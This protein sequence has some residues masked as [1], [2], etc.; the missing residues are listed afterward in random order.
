MISLK[1]IRNY[2]DYLEAQGQLESIFHSELN[3]EEG[4]SAEILAILIE[5]YERKMSPSKEDLLIDPPIDYI[6]DLVKSASKF[7]N[8]GLLEKGLKL[9]EESGELSAEILKLVGYKKNDL[10][11]SQIDQNILLESVDCLIMIFDIIS[12]MDFNKS[13]IVEMAEKQVN[14]WLNSINKHSVTE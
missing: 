14:K 9:S 7:E 13:Q 1:P 11:K 12:Y 10:S 5:N 6:Y 2:D 8:H 3:S 4:Q